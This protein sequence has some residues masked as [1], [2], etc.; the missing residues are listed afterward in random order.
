MSLTLRK[1]SANEND[2]GTKI[3]E[4]RKRMEFNLNPDT[5]YSHAGYGTPY[6]SCI[7]PV[8]DIQTYITDE[9]LLAFQDHFDFK[10]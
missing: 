1:I 4:I 10:R 2:C 8:D 7:S 9:E 6:S 5:E 3:Y